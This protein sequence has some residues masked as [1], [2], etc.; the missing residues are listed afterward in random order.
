[1][2]AATKCYSFAVKLSL[3]NDVMWC[4]SITSPVNDKYTA[5]NFIAMGGSID[6]FAHAIPLKV[7][8]MDSFIILVE[9]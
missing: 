8:V 2:Q 6:D 1:M 3:F 5:V 4:T 9:Q 7:L